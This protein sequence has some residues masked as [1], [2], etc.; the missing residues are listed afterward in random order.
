MIL[1]GM[2]LTGG[3]ALNS[4]PPPPP[5]GGTVWTY[6]PG[7]ASSGFNDAVLSL[8][9]NGSTIIAFGAE[10]GAA[11]S[12]DGVTWTNQNGLQNTGWANF[13]VLASAWNGSIFL[14]GGSGAKVATTTDGINY[15]YIST[16]R[17][18]NYDTIND[19]VWDGT[20]FI[21]ATGSAL[22]TTVDG[23][24]FTNRVFT[25]LDDIYSLTLKNNTLLIT[26]GL[27]YIATSTDGGDT[28]TARN[29]LREGTWGTTARVY[30]SATDGNIF[31]VGGSG[32]RIATSPD[33]ITWTFRN[34]LQNT[35]WG[36][37]EVRKMIWDGSTFVAAGDT[38]KVATSV[39]GE[40]W[41][42][43]DTL[44]TTAWGSTAFGQVRA[45]LPTHGKILAGGPQVRLATSP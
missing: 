44:S 41:T 17:T 1:Q 19:I 14:I 22:T 40:N 24:A 16:L 23:S 43:Y 8:T 21:I 31:V 9:S 3:L 45:L 10:G 18:L 2:T 30:A 38:G 27:G 4:P 6:Q 34:S 36:T 12:T 26:M 15:T 33:G 13:G 5:P 42:Y 29:N 28:V 37:A 39:D 35:T 11:T 7:L 32:G 25:N 20:K